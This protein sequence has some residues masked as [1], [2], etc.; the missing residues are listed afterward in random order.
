MH[1][2][3]SAQGINQGQGNRVRFSISLP[4]NVARDLDQIVEGRGFANRSQAVGSM[5]EDQMLVF[6]SEMGSEV[7]MGL[8][9]F[10]FEH[11]RRGLQGE[12][13]DIQH[14]Y[15]KEIISIQL[16]HLE[17]DLTL[18]IL[19]VQGPA[20]LLREITDEMITRKGVR[21]GNLQ[22]SAAVLPPLHVPGE[23]ET[24]QSTTAKSRTA[25]S[26]ITD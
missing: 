8:I 22:L 12:L 25:G 4:L 11:R 14:K 26:K 20:S 16:V 21:Q 24:A 5:V 7:M 17:D 23:T 18:Q 2:A 15:L 6:R 13:T 1:G 3:G 9:T 19:L 10:I